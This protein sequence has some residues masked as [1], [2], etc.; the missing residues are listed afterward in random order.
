MLKKLGL[1]TFCAASAF[2]MHNAELNLND[3]D[4]EFGVK[5]DAA[6]YNENIEPEN[7]YVGGRILHGSSDNSD[8]SSNS[9]IDD[10]LEANLLFQTKVKESEST[11]GMGIKFNYTKDYSSI[12]LGLE[13]K[14]K[15][16]VVEELPLYIKGALYYAP[17]V[18]S[19][20]DA[21]NFFE[22][23]VEV[24]AEVMEN[25]AV[26]IGYR[27]IDTNYDKDGGGDVNYN[28]SMYLGLRFAF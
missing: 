5:F 21:E 19:F 10:Y 3:K 16:E 7:I 2:A 26:T 1:I 4:L 15:I 8:F 11:F 17:E 9:D 22:Y 6:Q 18:L 13:V 25:A 27:S 14:H 24:E 28:K 12:P 23:R 20:R